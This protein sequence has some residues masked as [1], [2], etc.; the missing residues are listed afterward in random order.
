[1]LTFMPS[2]LPL[3]NIYHLITSYAFTIRQKRNRFLTEGYKPIFSSFFG[4]PSSRNQKW[5][6]MA[7]SMTVAIYVG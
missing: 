6:E 4:V 1:M 7:S 2:S 3:V 5:H